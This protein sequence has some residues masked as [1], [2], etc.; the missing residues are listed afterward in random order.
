MTRSNCLI[1]AAKRLRQAWKEGKGIGVWIVPTQY[2]IWK[3]LRW[4][5]FAV[6]NRVNPDDCENYGVIG[7]KRP[8]R[9]PPILFEG[10][11]RKGI[12]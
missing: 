10:E 8:R 1:Y 6:I 4:P 7:E 3:W 5:H 2:N 12:D 11:V 9:I